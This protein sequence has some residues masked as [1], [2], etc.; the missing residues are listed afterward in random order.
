VFVGAVDVELVGIPVLFEL[1]L[2]GGGGERLLAV[3]HD[4]V[5]VV[6]LPADG[7]VGAVFLGGHDAIREVVLVGPVPP[8]WFLPRWSS[9]WW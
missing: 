8:R 7:L 1:E 2:V 3:T 4:L 9:P 6:D 5:A